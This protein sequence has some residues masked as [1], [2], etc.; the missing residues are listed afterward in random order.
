MV[1]SESSAST[2]CYCLRQ[3]S[4]EFSLFI[5][6]LP[7]PRGKHVSWIAE[8]D[9][10]VSHCLVFSGGKVDH[11]QSSQIQAEAKKNLEAA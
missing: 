10:S 2:D 7:C 6:F 3:L 4:H 11:Y 9:A 8:V 1:L 5:L